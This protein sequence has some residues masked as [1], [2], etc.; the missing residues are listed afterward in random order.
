M[1]ESDRRLRATKPAD[2]KKIAGKIRGYAEE[3]ESYAEALASSKDKTADIEGF[4]MLDRA[5]S[6]LNK[7]SANCKKKIEK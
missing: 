1:D 7:F 3:I 4:K 6:N 5:F 2:L